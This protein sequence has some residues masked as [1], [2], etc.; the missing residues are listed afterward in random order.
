[1]SPVY[2]NRIYGVLKEE[3]T[4]TGLKMVH[5]DA[6]MSQAGRNAT[7]WVQIRPGSMGVLALGLAYVILRDKIYDQAFIDRYTQ[8]F[9]QGG[10]DFWALVTRD[11]SPIR[12]SEITGVPAQTILRLAREFSAA[13]PPLV[14]AGGS[15]DA[16]ETGLPNEGVA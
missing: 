11:Y 9:R 15:T 1:M 16:S 4:R 2:F 8:D 5:V 7:E 6:R 13:N 14:V 12:V 3:R 10:E